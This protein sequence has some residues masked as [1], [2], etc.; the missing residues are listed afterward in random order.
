M[1]GYANFSHKCKKM[2]HLEYRNLS[3]WAQQYKKMEAL[4]ERLQ[5]GL[6]PFGTAGEGSQ[7]YFAIREFHQK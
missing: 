2:R 4:K 5:R 1:A 6:Q 7:E 3:A